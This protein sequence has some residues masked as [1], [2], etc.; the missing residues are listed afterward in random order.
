MRKGLIFTAIAL[1]VVYNAS[2]GQSSWPCFHGPDRTNKSKETGL[3]QLWP[4]G[5]PKLLLTINGLGE[6]FS[7]VSIADGMI[8]TAGLDNNVP[9]VF[10][11]DLRGK[12]VWKK[13]S[14]AKWSTTASWASSYVGPRST[15]TY[16]NG[17]VYF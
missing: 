15:P 13:P 8:F 17:V 16:D 5:G 10:A 2:S 12:P 6:G 1:V 11:F 9:Y 3:A 14:G 4:A 7:S